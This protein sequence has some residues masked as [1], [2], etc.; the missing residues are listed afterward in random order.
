MDCRSVLGNNGAM[1][2]LSSWLLE[3]KLFIE[4]DDLDGI[5]KTKE[6]QKKESKQEKSKLKADCRSA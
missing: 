2:K 6:Q 1:L 5:V 4:K 3:W